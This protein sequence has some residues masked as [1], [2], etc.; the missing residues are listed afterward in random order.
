MLLVQHNT[1]LI[2]KLRTDNTPL[3]Q[4][5]TRKIDQL[6][7]DNTALMQSQDNNKQID[8]LRTEIDNI[9]AETSPLRQ[10]MA[11]NKHLIDMLRTLKPKP[12]VMLVRKQCENPTDYFYKTFA[13][14]QEGFSAN[15]EVWI[16]LDKLHQL[17]SE[18]SYSLK[19]TMTDYDGKKYRAVYEQFEVGPGNG[20]V[21]TVGKFNA[22]RSTLGDSLLA[23][24]SANGMKFSTKDR[25]QDLARG[26]PSCANKW[27]GGW[28]YRN[29]MH[30][31]PTGLSSATKKNGYKYVY[32]HYGGERGNDGADSWSEAEYLL[33]PN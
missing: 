33:V 15:G 2:N 5:N 6:M 20:Y 16:G 18:H 31:H 32:Y 11:E 14:Y 25:D 26:S 21:L 30:A 8:Q 10:V 24:Q 9:K 27:I 4:E 12:V 1:K 19:I 28:W 29:C 7:A 13:E 3:I 23:G 22:T 17:T